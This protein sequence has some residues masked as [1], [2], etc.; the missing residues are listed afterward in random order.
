MEVQPE[1]VVA[2][3]DRQDKSEYPADVRRPAG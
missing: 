3:F 2:G 1:E